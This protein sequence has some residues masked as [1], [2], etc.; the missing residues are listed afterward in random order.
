[1]T[2]VNRD[3]RAAQLLPHAAAVISV[4]QRQLREEKRA[5]LER[6]L[7]V[8]REMLEMLQADIAELDDM[9]SRLEPARR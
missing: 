5:S 9:E 2:V 3:Y 6:Q 4:L 7:A 8:R 1:M